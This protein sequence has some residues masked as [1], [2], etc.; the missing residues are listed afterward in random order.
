MAVAM[1]FVTQLTG[2]PGRYEEAIRTFH[3]VRE[4]EG[5]TIKEFVGLFG[6]PD[7]IIF[8]ETDSEAKAAQF[9]MQFGEVATVTSSL[10]VK[11]EDLRW[12][13]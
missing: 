9:V 1:L 11:I 2:L 7:A 6:K 4:T 5:V 10:A 12:T 8:F 3:R 13:R